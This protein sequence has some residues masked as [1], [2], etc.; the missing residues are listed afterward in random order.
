MLKVAKTAPR[1]SPLL[2]IT[3]GDAMAFGLGVMRLAPA[4]FWAMTPRELFM[5]AEGLGGFRQGV[6][7]SQHPSGE[8][9][10]GLMQAYPDQDRGEC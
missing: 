9:L 3:W 7:A 5:A 10:R 6:E 1:T 2:G 8:E 4:Q